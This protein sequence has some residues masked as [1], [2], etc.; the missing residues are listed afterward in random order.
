LLDVSDTCCGVDGEFDGYSQLPVA[1]SPTLAVRLGA[2]KVQG[3]VPFHEAAYL[4]GGRT[5][6]GFDGQRFAGDAL[7]F[8][9][10]ELRAELGNMTLLSFPV[11]FGVFTLTDIG[12]VYVGGA[13]PGGWHSS[14]GGGVWVAPL[15]KR[16]TASL[17]AARSSEQTA[18]YLNA[19]FEF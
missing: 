1:L 8:G 11:D 6:R 16:F 13:S 5:L 9:S 4:G 14:F 3:D 12:R 7:I 15:Q 2:K 19:G 18:L 17:A 10:L